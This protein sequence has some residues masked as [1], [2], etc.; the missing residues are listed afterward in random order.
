MY[1]LIE[2]KGPY[3][4]LEKT[5]CRGH[6]SPPSTILQ[7]QRDKGG[8]GHM[9]TGKYGSHVIECEEKRECSNKEPPVA[10]RC[11][12]LHSKPD[13]DFRSDQWKKLMAEGGFRE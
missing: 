8:I 2:V 4:G 1:T 13:L 3:E 11:A 7:S 9:T 5:V 10:T 6:E 12:A